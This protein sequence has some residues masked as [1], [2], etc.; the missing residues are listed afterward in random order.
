MRRQHP[1]RGPVAGLELPE[2][3]S[4]DDGR[5]RRL[6]EHAADEGLRPLAAP[7]PWPDGERARLGGELEGRRGG[8]LRQQP[9]GVGGQRALDRLQHPALEDRHHRL[10]PGER[11]VAGIRAEGSERRE[12]RRAR[13]PGRASDDDDVAGRVLV[14]LRAPPRHEL[15]DR[16]RHPRV[17]GLH[18][19]EPDVRHFEIAREIGAR[20]HVVPDLLAVERDRQVGVDRGSGHLA[21]RCV[22]PGRQVDGEHRR[23]EVVHLLDQPRCAGPRLAFEAGAE[24]G[25]DQNVGIAEILLLVLRLRVDDEDVSVLLLEHPRGHAAVASVRAAAADDREGASVSEVLERVLGD[26]P[27]RSLHELLDGALVALL[28]RAHLGGCV[29]RLKH[30]GRR[31]GRRRSQAPWSAS[32]RGRSR[33]RGPSRPRPSSAPRAGPAVSAGPRSRSRAT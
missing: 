25:V 18:R 31:R 2:R 16:S 20:G 19:L 26:G 12:A 13:Q 14:A 7:E 4:V 33:L 22:H 3:V 11:H 1:R 17:L 28:G 9:V 8:V 29:E 23:A 15:E 30:P 21:R 5:Q 27:S 32:S 6:G 10:G 24:E